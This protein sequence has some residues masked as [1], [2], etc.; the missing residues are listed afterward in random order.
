MTTTARLE[1]IS[2]ESTMRGV[3]LDDMLSVRN[4]NI[5]RW[6]M[7]NNPSGRTRA[8]RVVRVTG[9]FVL[10]GLLLF[11]PVVSSALAGTY[12]VTVERGGLVSVDV[13]DR[14]K[15]PTTAKLESFTPASHGNVA[16]SPDNRSVSYQAKGDY[17]GADFFTYKGRDTQ[18][19]Q[20]YIGRVDVTVATP[21]RI[22]TLDYNRVAG[23]LGIILVLSIVLEIGLATVFS[24]K[25][26]EDNL[27]GKGLKIPI[28]V[29]VSGF[30]TYKYGLDIVSDLLSAFTDK[31]AAFD[32]SPPGYVITAFIVAGGSGTVNRLFATLGLRPPVQESA[33]DRQQAQLVVN[34]TRSPSLPPT[35]SVNVSI[36]GQ[37]VSTETGNRLPAQ[38]AY[39]LSPGSHT[40]Q[41]EAVDNT[42]EKRIV[43]GQ[44]NL[45]PAAIVELPMTL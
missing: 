44:V 12:Q 11:W 27:N 26:F 33:P 23:V 7:L 16:I 38:A 25:Y 18:T 2:L 42:G 24:W 31:G 36:D 45:A 20:D 32:K 15:A 37:L 10:M 19:N 21:Q 8:A 5:E 39:R 3:K 13:L 34:L 30:F 17:S 14:D 9:I 40:I 29:M 4:T 35:A 22:V 28:A 6:L 1:I 41:L 43:P